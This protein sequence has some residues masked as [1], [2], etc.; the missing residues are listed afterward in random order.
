MRRVLSVVLWPLLFAVPLAIVWAAMS[1]GHGVAAFNATYLGLALAIASLERIM[2]HERAWLEN[3][4][5]MLP[6]LLHTVLNKGVAQVLITVIVFMGIAGWVAPQEGGIWP[7]EW[8]LVFQLALGLVVIEFPLYWKHRL[9]HEWPWLWR[10]HAVHHS[11]TRLWFFNTGR[12]H[13]VD[14]L[15]GL[16]VGIPILLLLGA[17]DPVL[18]L[19]SAVTAFV[20][21]LTHCNI[22]MRCGVLS[23]VFNTPS[24]HRWHHSKD[25][26]EGNRNYG[27]NLML[28][29]QLFGSFYNSP[30][31][32]PRDI[33]IEQPMPENFLGQLKVPFTRQPL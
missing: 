13:L 30:R 27:E 12:F 32:P 22:E 23:Y 21:L 33:G 29:D 20:G 6:D 2:P 31:R 19:V 15:T 10:F 28:F 26:S 7:S 18:L 16:A 9:A 11:V 25:L 14:T 17:P 1:T 4:G 8:P 5:Q 24:L 3:D